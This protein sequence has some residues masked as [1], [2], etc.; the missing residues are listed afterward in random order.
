MVSKERKM[1]QLFNSRWKTGIAKTHK[2]IPPY[3]LLRAPASK[4]F[5]ES[6]K[7]TIMGS[8]LFVFPMANPSPTR[9]T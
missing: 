3:I 8:G 2:R 6:G 1:H 4:K 5:T 9:G 7:L